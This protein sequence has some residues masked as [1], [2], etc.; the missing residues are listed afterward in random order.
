MLI[1]LAFWV[2]LNFHEISKLRK[3]MHS[4]CLDPFIWFH[5]IFAFETKDRRIVRNPKLS[6]SYGV[7]FLAVLIFLAWILIEHDRRLLPHK[8][9]QDYW[10]FCLYLPVICR[11]KFLYRDFRIMIAIRLATVIDNWFNFF[12]TKNFKVSLCPLWTPGM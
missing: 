6:L 12:P 8:S 9:H 4:G 1:C 3:T 10:D 7:P 11:Q 2:V 5:I